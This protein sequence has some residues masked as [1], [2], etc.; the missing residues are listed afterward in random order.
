MSFL[1]RRLR[2]LEAPGL[3]VRVL[4]MMHESD[5]LSTRFVSLVLASLTR[6]PPFSR[7]EFGSGQ[8]RSFTSRRQPCRGTEGVAMGARG[9]M[10]D[11]RDDLGSCRYSAFD[12]SRAIENR[13]PA[14]STFHSVSSKPRNLVSYR[15]IQRYPALLDGWPYI[16]ETPRLLQVL[17]L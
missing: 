13:T 1:N 7:N 16:L 3:G 11:C 10:K 9:C 6:S 14:S 2:T 8:M 17:S 15:T 5:R 12:A 4:W